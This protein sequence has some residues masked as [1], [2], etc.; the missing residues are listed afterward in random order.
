MHVWKGSADTK[1]KKKVSFEDWI[2]A[3]FNGPK[4]V[5]VITIKLHLN[6][7]VLTISL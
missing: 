2:F 7:Y 1:K 4:V 3:V 5:K 6:K